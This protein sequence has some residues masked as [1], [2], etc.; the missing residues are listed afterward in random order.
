MQDG[1]TE[2]IGLDLGDRYS[3]YCVVDQESGEELE[4][5]RIRTTAAGLQRF[6]EGRTTARVALEVGTHS[7]WVSRVLAGR[8]G[9]TYVANARRLRMIYQNPRKSDEV[10]ARMLARVARM[11]PTL[12]SPIQHRTEEAQHDLV[13][14]RARDVAV[15]ARTQVVCALRG[16]IKSTGERFVKQSAESIG[17]KS[18]ARIPER[19]RESLGPLL[20]VLETLSEE[21][22]GYDRQIDR[23]ATERHPETAALTQVPGVGNL[24]ALA[25]VL[26]LESPAR[27]ARSRDV[28]AFLGLVPKRDQSGSTEKQLR[29]TKAGDRLVRTLLVQCAHY[30]LGRKGPSC[31]LR[32][33]GERIAKRGG[34]LA[35]RKAVVAVA[36]KLAVLLH[37][38]WRTGEVYEPNRSPSHA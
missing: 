35:K 24:T 16:L 29:I 32:C 15:A 38:L 31:D 2:S 9:E 22:K 30:I 10:D 21:I 11:D 1:I 17:T 20:K 27:F 13:V 3:A 34:P 37:V 8:C 18:L 14:V 23:L 12:L 25:F 7:P 33:Y 5:G 26:T 28:G 19:L 4:S 36:R 6:F